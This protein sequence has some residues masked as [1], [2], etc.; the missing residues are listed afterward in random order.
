MMVSGRKISKP[1]D[2]MEGPPMKSMNFQVV[3]TGQ[4]GYKERLG[5]GH[6]EWMGWVANFGYS[7]ILEAWAYEKD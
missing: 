2:W 7:R 3:P 1:R 4:E 5:P 6:R